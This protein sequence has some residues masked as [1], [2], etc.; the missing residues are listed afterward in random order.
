MSEYCEMITYALYSMS[1]VQYIILPF[2]RSESRTDPNH[3][4][5]CE[6]R[7]R[8]AISAVFGEACLQHYVNDVMLI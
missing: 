7:N 4:C 8:E 1:T 3:S 5:H 2:E 6:G